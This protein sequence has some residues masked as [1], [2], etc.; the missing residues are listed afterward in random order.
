MTRIGEHEGEHG[1]QVRAD[2]RRALGEAGEPHLAAADFERAEGDLGPRVGRQMACATSRN[3]PGV[4]ASISAAISTPR[5]MLSIGNSR[6]MTPVEATRICRSSQPTWAAVDRG[7][8]AGVGQALLAG[9]GVGVAGADDDAAS[10]VGR[11]AFAADD[12]RGGTDAVLREDAGRRRGPIADDERQIE[13][14]AVGP[15]AALDAGIAKPAGEFGVVHG[16]LP[17]SRDPE[18]SE[19]SALRSEDSASRLNILNYFFN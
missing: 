9:A 8:R 1:G 12:D 16:L 11:Q 6:P 10:I 2:H 14:I 13:P 18:S 5:V 19:G 7:H 17:F 3:A 4:V 15:H